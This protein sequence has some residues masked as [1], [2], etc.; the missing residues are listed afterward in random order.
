MTNQELLIVANEHLRIAMNE[1]ELTR[2]LM[3]RGHIESGHLHHYDIQF[4]HIRRWL[5]ILSNIIRDTKD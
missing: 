5:E 4:K 2:E 1:L 3:V